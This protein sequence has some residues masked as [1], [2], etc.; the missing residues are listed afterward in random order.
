MSRETPAILRIGKYQIIPREDWLLF[1]FIVFGVTITLG[2]LY[3][4][5]FTGFDDIIQYIAISVPLGFIALGTY[6]LRCVSKTRPCPDCGAPSQR[7][8]IQH[9]QKEY[10]HRCSACPRVIKTGIQKK[11]D[12]GNAHLGKSV[13]DEAN[14]K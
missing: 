5:I 3:Q 4:L 7:I 10:R 13:L 9:H 11:G 8:P 12:P 14:N 1:V 6:F 2:W